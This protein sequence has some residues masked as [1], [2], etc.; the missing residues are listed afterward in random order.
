[1]VIK[2]KIKFFQ[3]ENLNEYLDNS[4]KECLMK[5][6]NIK[7]DEHDYITLEKFNIRLGA[8]ETVKVRR[9]DFF[10]GL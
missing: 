8:K 4:I 10:N 7:E 5:N 1:L 6:P 3:K 9:D 2:E